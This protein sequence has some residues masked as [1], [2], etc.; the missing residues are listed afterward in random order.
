MPLHEEENGYG[1]VKNGG[2]PPDNAP[3]NNGGHPKPPDPSGNGKENVSRAAKFLASAKDKI[4]CKSCRKGENEK[5]NLPSKRFEEEDQSKTGCFSCL[6]KKEQIK[7]SI[8][9]SVE[10]DGKEIKASCWD[11]MKCCGTK[12]K[13]GEPQGCLPCAKRKPAW[14]ERRDSIL[15]DLPSRITCWTR[16]KN[17]MKK[18]FC[19]HLCKKKRK[20][21]DLSVSRRASTL[22]KKKSLT[23]T[24]LP[25]ED[26]TPKLDLSLVE[27]SSPMKA[28]IPV[29]PICLAWF[30]LVMNCFLPGTGTA[31]SGIF[32]CA[33]VNQ[34]SHKRTACDLVLAPSSLTVLWVLVSVLR[35]SFVWLDGDGPYGGV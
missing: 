21:E 5:S 2:L 15:S 35:Y 26:Q 3:N 6:K 28:A 12:N 25:I 23:P 1:V 31:L 7:Q 19:L 4:L 16:C 29:L 30:C 13:S 18:L 22:S 34:D 27:H 20:F 9:I 33:L 32:A 24:A 8:K 14:E 11:R 17:F 10:E